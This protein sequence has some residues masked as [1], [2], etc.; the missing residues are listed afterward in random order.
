MSG[1][2]GGT[3]SVRRGRFAPAGR[4]PRRSGKDRARVRAGLRLFDG[5][6]KPLRTDP[7]PPCLIADHR[8]RSPAARANRATAPSHFPPDRD[9]RAAQSPPERD[10]GPVRAQHP[11]TLPARAPFT[12]GIREG[13]MPVRSRW[14]VRLRKR[15][16]APDGSG[17]AGRDRGCDQ[18][19]ADRR[20]P[21]WMGP[22]AYPPF[23]TRTT[24]L[25]LLAFPRE[26]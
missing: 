16:D 8:S 20:C 5:R 2:R 15:G 13:P 10:R 19:R 4:P 11:L 1:G 18:R 26:S 7:L 12:T 21:R 24:S 23:S 14:T 22:P 6:R 17:M 3:G 9:G 25:R